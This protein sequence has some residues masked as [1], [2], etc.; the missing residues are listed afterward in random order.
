[1]YEIE[2][3]AEVTEWLIALSGKDWARTVQV[4]DMLQSQGPEIGMPLSK[5]LGDGLFELR[6][7]CEGALGESATGSPAAP[8]SFC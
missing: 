3:H 6:F 8:G 4:L 2:T 7:T 5:A 1:M